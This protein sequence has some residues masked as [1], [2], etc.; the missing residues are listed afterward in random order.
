MSV[1]SSDNPMREMLREIHNPPIMELSF[2]ITYM[3]F[4]SNLPGANELNA[5]V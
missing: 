3:E 5:S 1:K 4:N 2:E